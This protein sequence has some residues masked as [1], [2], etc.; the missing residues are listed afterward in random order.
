MNDADLNGELVAHAQ[1]RTPRLDQ[2][3]PP[4]QCD[5]AHA[6]ALLGP[7]LRRLRDQREQDTPC[8]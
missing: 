4:D 6:D 8:L 3:F 1:G 7:S 2:V 5:Y